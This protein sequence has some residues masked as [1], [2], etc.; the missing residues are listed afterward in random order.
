MAMNIKRKI[1]FLGLVVGYLK[2]FKKGQEFKM[3]NNKET[4]Y[5]FWGYVLIGGAFAFI[6]YASHVY[7][8]YSTSYPRDLHGF[9][10]WPCMFFAL[11]LTVGASRLFSAAK[12]ISG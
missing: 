8:M 10:T 3:L 5:T 6:I 1:H 9:I 11:C 7:C 2:I 4:R 12:R